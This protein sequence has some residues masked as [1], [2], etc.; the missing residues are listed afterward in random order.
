MC[1]AT[2]FA[3]NAPPEPASPLVVVVKSRDPW[4]RAA[5]PPEHRRRTRLARCPDVILQDLVQEGQILTRGVA[6]GSRQSTV[7][8]AWQSDR[9]AN[10]TRYLIRDALEQ[11]IARLVSDQSIAASPTLVEG[12]GDI[13][14]AEGIAEKVLRNIER[15]D[16]AV[17][18]MTFIAMREDVEGAAGIPNP[19]VMLEAGYARANLSE[20]NL[21]YPLN[22]AY[23]APLHLPFDLGYCGIVPFLAREDCSDVAGVTQMLADA[24]FDKMLPIYRRMEDEARAVAASQRPNVSLFINARRGSNTGPWRNYTLSIDAQAEHM[25]AVVDYTIE[26]EV[27]SDL[28]QQ[29]Q[30]HRDLQPRRGQDQSLL[31][32]RNVRSSA[33]GGPV[34]RSEEPVTI[35]ALDLVGHAPTLADPSFA[36]REVHVRVTV[37]SQ[38]PYTSS[39]PIG[40]LLGR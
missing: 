20:Q 2:C 35:Y 19:N 4:W 1:F 14:G 22:T 31:F 39:M 5:P 3:S 6:V 37:P 23:G 10:T 36:R 33:S 24:L 8:Y 17:F 13:F 15:A 40:D 18:D 26:V 7:F 29:P 11:A 25:D 9:D 16:F 32:R 27:P 21:L 34:I 38:S 30:S 28:V 12:P